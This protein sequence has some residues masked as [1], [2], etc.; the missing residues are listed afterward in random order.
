MS[1]YRDRMPY[2]GTRWGSPKLATPESAQGVAGTFDPREQ[3]S[4]PHPDRQRRNSHPTVGQD[5]NLLL[6]RQYSKPAGADAV[7]NNELLTLPPFNTVDYDTNLPFA[8]LTSLPNNHTPYNDMNATLP[9]LNLFTPAELEHAWNFRVALSGYNS[10]PEI[11]TTALTQ[12]PS[13]ASPYELQP[14]LPDLMGDTA[15]FD[16]SGSFLFSTTPPAPPATLSPLANGLFDLALDDDPA[17][18]SCDQQSSY[19]EMPRWEPARAEHDHTYP[20]PQD[21]GILFGMPATFPLERHISRPTTPKARPVD[22]SQ[23]QAVFPNQD[24]LPVITPEAPP[25]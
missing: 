7:L 2:W 19:L 4:P 14:V 21:G 16:L 9:P 23:A 12:S 8:P 24:P 20:T 1:E 18:F 25:F 15:E 10:S 3:V 5:Q 13:F 22:Q 17:P 6:R 11:K